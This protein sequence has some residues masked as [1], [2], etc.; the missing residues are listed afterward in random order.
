MFPEAHISF[1]ALGCKHIYIPLWKELLYIFYNSYTNILK[2]NLE[3]KKM[4]MPL[5]ARFA[6]KQETH[7]EMHP[8]HTL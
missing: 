2:N 8:N 7:G 6:K 3:K 1:D 5:L 4:F